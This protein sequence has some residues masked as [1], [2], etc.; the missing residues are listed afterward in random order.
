MKQHRK[1]AMVRIAVVDGKVVPDFQG[2]LVGRGGYLHLSNVCLERFV[3]SK[4]KEFRSLKVKIERDQ[5]TWIVQAIRARLDRK[6]AL[7]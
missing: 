5:R 6:A 7:E 1:D 2:R 3:K 4:A